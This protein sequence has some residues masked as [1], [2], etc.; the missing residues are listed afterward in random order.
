MTNRPTWIPQGLYP[1]DDHYID[2]DGATVH[3]VDE[4][5]GPP[6]LLLHGNPTCL[7]RYVINGVSDRYQCSAPDHPGFGLSRAPAGY[8][9][10]P[11]EHAGCSSDSSSNSI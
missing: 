1:F 2:V 6:L 11:A 3:Y 9:F 4:G 7:Y 10:S 5:D 8:G